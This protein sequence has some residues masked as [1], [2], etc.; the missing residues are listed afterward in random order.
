[1]TQPVLR[2]RFW[3][4]H[5]ADRTVSRPLLRQT[6][7]ALDRLDQRSVLRVAAVQAEGMVQTEK[8]H[9]IDHLTR[10]AMTGHAML[11]QFRD[12]LAHGDLLLADELR[13]FSDMARI[14]SGEVIA[15]TIDTFCRESRGGR[16]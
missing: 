3:P 5:P 16:P 1:M 9:E 8:V 13:F 6:T 14:G 7:R 15:D 10:E 11:S 12:V 2:D 4:Q